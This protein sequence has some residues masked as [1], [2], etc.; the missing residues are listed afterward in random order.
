MEHATYNP[1]NPTLEHSIAELLRVTL[2]L[3][4]PYTWRVG[5]QTRLYELENVMRHTISALESADADERSRTV[6]QCRRSKR[7]L[8]IENH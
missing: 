6:L 5:S 8:E 4:E 3:I 2:S 7:H 1:T